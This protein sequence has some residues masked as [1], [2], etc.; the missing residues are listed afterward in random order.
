M[1]TMKVIRG[2]PAPEELAALVA[3]LLMARPSP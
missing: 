3:V 1:S 2:N